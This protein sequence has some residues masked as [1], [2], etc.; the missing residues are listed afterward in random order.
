MIMID[1][2][3]K[4]AEKLNRMPNGFPATESGVEIRILKKYLARRMQRWH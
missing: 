4:L 3:K 2:Y 1:S